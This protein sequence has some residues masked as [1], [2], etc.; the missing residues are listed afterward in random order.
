MLMYVCTGWVSEIWEDSFTQGRELPLFFS[1]YDVVDLLIINQKA[2]DLTEKVTL[3]EGNLCVGAQ[4]RL[5]REKR[6][7]SRPQRRRWRDADN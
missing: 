1:S 5:L 4:V 3:A 6:V 2:N 7:G